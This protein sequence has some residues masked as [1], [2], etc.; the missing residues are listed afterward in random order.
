[1][2]MVASYPKSG[3]TW[4]S[5][6]LHTSRRG[7]FERSA[8]VLRD[9]PDVL[10]P[11]Q[12][13]LVAEKLRQGH[14]FFVKSHAPYFEDLPYAAHIKQCIYLVRNPF[15]IMI[16]H[17]NNFLLDGVE[18]V[19]SEKGMLHFYESFLRQANMKPFEIPGQEAPVGGWNNHVCSWLRRDH[20]IPTYLV[21]YEDLRAD[22]FSVISKLNEDLNLGF[23]L[24]NMRAGC[25]LSSFENMKKT[26][27]YELTHNIPGMFYSEQRKKSFVEEGIQFVNK[28]RVN[29]YNAVLDSALIE[30]GT[31]AC[32]EG[33]LRAGYLDEDDTPR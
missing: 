15:D 26:E 21:R 6:L 29:N 20:G 27:A 14:D 7:T 16:S 31:R 25:R 4:F 32:R 23:S 1:M 13:H 19:R 10:V 2:I 30:A 11:R 9:H 5:F 24:E 28:G 22:T 18:Q 17:V 8:D 33:L 12:Q 3:T